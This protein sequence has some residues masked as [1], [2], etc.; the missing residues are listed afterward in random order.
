MEMTHELDRKIEVAQAIMEQLEANQPLSGV[1][2]QVR[3]LANMMGDMV[4]VALMDIL[5][6]GLTN[7]PYQG[8]PFTDDAYRKAG[9]QYMK[10]CSVEDI[11]KLD[12]DEIVNEPWHER[13]PVKDQIITLSVYEV[14]NYPPSPTIGPWDSQ[15]R[16]NLKLQLSALHSSVESILITLRACVYDYVGGIWLTSLRE[17]DRIALC[18]ILTVT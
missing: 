9:I 3:L 14:E 15:E 18:S 10:L 16:A 7:V 8:K 5:I 17:K 4:K 13:I 11:S 2:S 1:L 6:H 12:V